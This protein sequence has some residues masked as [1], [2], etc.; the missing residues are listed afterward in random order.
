MV[1][2]GYRKG[3]YRRVTAEILPPKQHG[4][5]KRLTALLNSVSFLLPALATS[6]RSDHVPKTVRYSGTRIAFSLAGVLGGMIAPAVLA[7]IIGPDVFHKWFYVP[8]VYILYWGVAMTAL[9][10]IPET[11]DVSLHSL[12]E[13]PSIMVPGGAQKAFDSAS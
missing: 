2:K 13:A 6:F 4:G 9:L 7:G 5:P 11:R 1:T 8:A 12:D 3:V 10:F